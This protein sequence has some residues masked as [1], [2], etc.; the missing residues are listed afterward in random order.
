MPTQFTEL[1]DSQWQ[2]IEKELDGHGQMRK[3]KY[4]MRLVMNAILWL[5]RT[6]CQW[7]NLD[8]SYPYWQLVYY[9]FRK[10]TKAGLLPKVPTGAALQLR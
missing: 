5:T 4:S 1:T 8:R 6:G 7:R 9:Y 10:W 2:V 3:R